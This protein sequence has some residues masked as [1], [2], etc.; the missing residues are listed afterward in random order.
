VELPIDTSSLTFMCAL[1]PV[2]VMEEA[3]DRPMVDEQGEPMYSVSLLVLGPGG[4]QVLPVNVA[5]EPPPGVRPGAFVKVSGL[6]ASSWW[7]GSG[8]TF[9]AARIESSNGRAERS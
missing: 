3:T 2:P 5:G 4:A 9:T 1:P 7:A 6:V 8:I